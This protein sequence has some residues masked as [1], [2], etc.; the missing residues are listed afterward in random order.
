MKRR[1]CRRGFRGAADGGIFLTGKANLFGGSRVPRAPLP[2]RIE[3][4]RKNAAVFQVSGRIETIKG[5]KSQERAS[6]SYFY[7]FL[8]KKIVEQFFYIGYNSTIFERENLRMKRV[9]TNAKPLALH[10]FPAYMYTHTARR[11]KRPRAVT[12]PVIRAPCYRHPVKRSVKTHLP[13]LGGPAGIVPRAAKSLLPEEKSFSRAVKKNMPA[14]KSSLPEEKDFLP[15]VKK[16]VPAAKPLLPEEKG[17][18]PEAKGTAWKGRSGVKREKERP[19]QEAAEKIQ[20][21]R[22]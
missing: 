10:R 6:F 4:R 15:A 8:H 7:R 5:N 17:F 18:L 12:R 21:E 1:A 20:G 9:H 13:T 2:L 22:A 3:P 19:P 16:N 11:V 14:A